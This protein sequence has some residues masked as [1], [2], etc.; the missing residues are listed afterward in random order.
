MANKIFLSSVILLWI[1]SPVAAQVTGVDM[2]EKVYKTIDGTALKAYIFKSS[3]EQTGAMPAIAFFHGGGWVF[4]SPEEFFGACERYARK[5]FVTVSF[6]YRLSM[7]ADG[8]YPHPEITPVESVLDARSALR[9]LRENAAS[10]GIDPGK[11]IAGGQSAGGQLAMATVLMDDYNEDSDNLD[12]SPVPDALLLFS[13]SVNT[14]EAWIDWI[15]GDKHDQIW[16]ISPYH[17]LKKGMPPAIG[18]HGEDDC[19]VPIYAVRLFQDKMNELGNRYELIT[20]P[21]EG[22]YLGE[23]NE[24]Y[25]RLFDEEI[26][27][28]TD[29]FLVGLG[30]ME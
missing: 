6:Q 5:G 23:G 7:Q 12:V 16:A 20:F 26:L 2:Q 28:L 19:M 15:L 17:N 9:W 1:V 18:F 21:G 24:K 11:I 29:R 22:H 14:M 27:E 30:Y 13:S 8:T 25:S 4:G 10:L 3:E